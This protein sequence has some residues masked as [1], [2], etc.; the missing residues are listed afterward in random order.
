MATSVLRLSRLKRCDR[1]SG[2]FSVLGEVNLDLRT[3]CWSPFADMEIS[4]WL[5]IFSTQ[6]MSGWQRPQ[7]PGQKSV[8]CVAIVCLILTATVRVGA[9]AKCGSQLARRKPRTS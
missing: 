6:A 8:A 3:F 5:K 7:S 1:N 4:P 9:A 2:P